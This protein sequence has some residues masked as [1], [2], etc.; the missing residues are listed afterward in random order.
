MVW[1]EDTCAHVDESTVT[2]S[3][4]RVPTAV[5]GESSPFRVL[6]KSVSCSTRI[7]PNK[8]N[9]SERQSSIGVLSIFGVVTVRTVIL[10]E[11]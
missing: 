2:N 6:R 4:K 5:G 11:M 8:H 9:P 1:T 3:N 10:S 7:T